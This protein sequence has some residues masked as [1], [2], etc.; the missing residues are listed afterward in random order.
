M[1]YTDEEIGKFVDAEIKAHRAER[2]ARAQKSSPRMVSRTLAD[3][4][5]LDGAD[6]TKVRAHAYCGHGIA[7]VPEGRRLFVKMSVEENLDWAAIWR[8]RCLARNGS[9]ASTACSRSCATSAAS[10]PANCRRPAAD[11]GDRPGPD[12]APRSCCS[13]SRR[14]GWRRPSSTTCRHHRPR[15][16]RRRAVLLVEQNVRRRSTS[17]TAPTYWSGRIVAPACPPT[18]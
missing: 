13:T 14:S 6:M 2:R 3:G 17:P 18:C 15:A 16:P 9:S 5:S 7:L 8:R 4:L 10:R 12:G 11:G 1:G